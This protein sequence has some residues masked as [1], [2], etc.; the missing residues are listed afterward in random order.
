MAIA[1]P[2]DPALG[3]V[4]AI[5]QAGSQ[6]EQVFAEVG[7]HLGSAHAI[8]AGLN[9]GL[10]SLS[11]ELS[12]S[13]IQGASAA[14]QDIASRLRGLADALP[15]E[16]ALLGTI[17]ASAARASALLKQLIQHIHLITVIARSARIEAAS[18][19]GDRDDFL[20]FT[21]EASDLAAA[22]K[23]SIMTCSKEQQQLAQA[24]TAALSGQHE[25]EKRY[26]D[27]LLSV[28]AELIS[29]FTG[30]K[31][32]QSQGDQV[33]QLARSSTMRI[34]EAVGVAIVSLQAGDSTRQRLEHICR[35]LRQVTAADGDLTPSA[36]SLV[37]LLQGAQLKNTVSEFEADIGKINGSLALLSADSNAMVAHGRQLYGGKDNDMASFLAV[38]KQRLAEASQ[39][40]S[41]CG[42]AKVSVDASI[43]TLEGVLVKF[44]SAIS[45][46]DET[47]VDITLIGMNAGLKA[48]HLGEKGR[49]FVV[50]ANE[51]KQ[52]AD[53]ISGAA[54]LLD[55]VLA[56]IEQAADRL[57]TLRSEEE[58]LHVADLEASI[59]AAVEEIESGNG[60]LV[61]LMEHLTHESVQFE[62]LMTGA[63][64]TMSG[65]GVKFAA[66]PGLADLL[67]QANRIANT[68]S[69]ADVENA[70]EL[71]DELYMQYT[72]EL[73]RDVHCKL[74]ERF[75]ISCRRS[76]AAPSIAAAD[77]EDVLF[78]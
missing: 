17:G 55:P 1:A 73:E 75:G 34:G 76:V 25:F 72:M 9:G 2:P 8:F 11:D 43:A 41:A 22:V 38:M 3:A 4:T 39:L 27:R 31:Q 37:C 18:L 5:E 12:G 30:I 13:K 7:G 74:S 68:L 23:S 28:S 61:A 40:I 36:A 47:V 71:F 51:L 56:E 48:G 78:F 62:T 53:R 20:S 29:T 58:S 63:R 77:A 57:K 16:T 45:T 70:G 60:R 65:L 46:L 69:S 35:G 42:Q 19:E 21:R 15:A 6:V 26:H 64:K 10:N 67:E 66:L 32:L 24:I 50:I 14:F 49:A 59:A 33:A 52:T 44:R 54:K